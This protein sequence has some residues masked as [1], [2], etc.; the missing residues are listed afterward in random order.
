MTEP[1]LEIEN[2]D[3]RYRTD[4]GDV[5][6]VNDASFEVNPGQYHGLVGESGCGKSTI[7]KAIVGG[8]D[9]NGEVTNG[10]IKLGGEE[11]QDLSDKEFSDQV[12]W[13]RISK[14]PQSSMNALDPVM[15]ID[16]QALDLGKYH[17]DWTKEETLD[18]LAELFD[19]VGLPTDRMDDYPH[20]FSGGMQQRVVIALS[21]LLEPDLIIA[22]EPTTALDV[23]MQ[24]QIMA[25]LQN[26]KEDTD[27]AM[28]LITHDISLVFEECDAITVMHG[29]QVA[30]TGSA[31]DLFDNP[32]HPYSI[33]LQRTFPDVR[34]PDQE[35]TT[36]KGDPPVLT[37]DVAECSFADRCPWALPECRDGNPPL[38]PT[39]GE[40][41]HLN[42]C[43]RSDEMD[44]LTEEETGQTEVADGRS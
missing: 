2:L 31:V 19:I 33:L 15:R 10:T 7:A 17:T 3:I 38:E 22:D 40:P 35:L 29:G 34:Y 41:A 20:Q 26:I 5:A 39:E 44:I 16:K 32:R 9:S 27:V 11:I 4:E 12:R 43:I 37:G 28:L 24:D 42:S 1:V 8:L 23:I 13:K 14:I 36:I 30:E 25:H 18:R 21:L 6:A